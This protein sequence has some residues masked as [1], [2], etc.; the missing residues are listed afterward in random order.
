M[1]VRVD[2][3]IIPLPIFELKNTTNNIINKLKLYHYGKV[4]KRDE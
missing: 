3:P 4:I 1:D 2:N